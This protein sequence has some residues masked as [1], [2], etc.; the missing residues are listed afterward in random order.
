MMYHFEISHTLRH[1]LIER[2]RTRSTTINLFEGVVKEVRCHN[3][4][5]FLHTVM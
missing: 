4:L 2:D 3:I 5:T 1:V